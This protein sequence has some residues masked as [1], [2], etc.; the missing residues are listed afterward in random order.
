LSNQ[1]QPRF[2]KISVQFKQGSSFDKIANPLLP[3]YRFLLRHDG[4]RDPCSI[5]CD[6]T[7]SK[8]ETFA[9]FAAEKLE[10][11]QRSCDHGGTDIEMFNYV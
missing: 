10:N 3:F 1:P 9:P 5:V 11:L 2:R 8:H 6:F 4:L 7:H